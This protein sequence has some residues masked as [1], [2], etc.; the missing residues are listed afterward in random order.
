MQDSNRF[1]HL[2]HASSIIDNI[3][4]LSWSI[5]SMSVPVPLD[6]PKANHV[7]PYMPSPTSASV[8]NM[9]KNVLLLSMFGT[10]CHV[11]QKYPNCFF[12]LCVPAVM[13]LF[14]HVSVCVCVCACV[15]VC[16]C[17]SVCVRVCVCARV[18]VRARVCV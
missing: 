12:S 11:V 16:V 10:H 15:C 6:L 8:L 7:P 4:D 14:V 5:L 1:L 9:D 2:D 17:E 13:F 18:R 3:I